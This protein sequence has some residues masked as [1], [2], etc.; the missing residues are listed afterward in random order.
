MARFVSD[1]GGNT[2]SSVFQG[3]GLL[4]DKLLFLGTDYTGSGKLSLFEMDVDG[5]LKVKEVVPFSEKSGGVYGVCDGEFHAMGVGSNYAGHWA[6]NGSSWRQL[7]DIDT[8]T[9][10]WISTYAILQFSWQNKIH[11]LFNAGENYGGISYITYSSSGFQRYGNPTDLP[12][13]CY[14]GFH[15]HFIYKNEMYVVIYVDNKHNIFKVDGTKW[16]RVNI[17]TPSEVGDGVSFLVINGNLYCHQY[18]PSNQNW[19]FGMDMYKLNGTTWEKKTMN[20]SGTYGYSIA[21]VKY[22][23]SKDR[24][25]II[26]TSA[27]YV[28]SMGEETL[29]YIENNNLPFRLR[30]CDAYVL[31]NGITHIIDYRTQKHFIINDDGSFTELDSGLDK[32]D[33]I[34][35]Y[36]GVFSHVSYKNNIYAFLYETNLK[37]DGNKWSEITIENQDKISFSL[38]KSCI[39]DDKI[40]FH[41]TWERHIY[42]F[43]GEKVEVITTEAPTELRFTKAIFSHNGRLYTYGNKVGWAETKDFYWDGQKWNEYEVEFVGNASSSYGNSMSSSSMGIFGY[44][45]SVFFMQMNYRTY[46][47]GVFC[48]EDGKYKVLCELPVDLMTYYY[49]N[50]MPLLFSKNKIFAICSKE[51]YQSGATEVYLVELE[52]LYEYIEFIKLFFKWNPEITKG[53]KMQI[54]AENWNELCSAINIL[55]NKKGM[56]NFSFTL[57]QP[58]AQLKATM[59]NEV[60]D[61][62]SWTKASNLPAKVSKGDKCM[63]SFFIELEKIVNNV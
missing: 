58:S 9:Y 52:E 1:L 18:R 37:Y 33:K 59:F 31:H 10:P 6:W 39:Y 4:N 13:N 21:D 51:K 61:S 8:K 54:T 7:E 38:N 63:A 23:S 42:G 24:V 28:Y 44:N 48:F 41:D 27:G 47:C 40:C 17:S 36:S 19:I 14:F 34:N 55:R 22:V 3:F 50:Q 62:L 45:D 35:S 46:G 56:K 15:S 57:A 53:S 25:F 12:E 16:T 32:I 11:I 29:N 26:N 49:A 5:T 30:D 20:Y 43:D 60:I 2:T